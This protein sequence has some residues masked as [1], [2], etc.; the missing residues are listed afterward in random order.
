M[1]CTKSSF[2]ASSFRIIKDAMLQSEELPL[3]DVIDDQQWEAALIVTT[4]TLEM[5]KIQSIPLQSLSG[6]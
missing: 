1:S 3:A 4:L 5:T 6:D 2:S